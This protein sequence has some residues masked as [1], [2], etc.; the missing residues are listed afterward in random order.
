[1]YPL[2]LLA[3][4]PALYLTISAAHAQQAAPQD[5]PL[6]RKLT[7]CLTWLDSL[8]IIPD[9]PEPRFI[10]TW[11]QHW[12]DV[13]K[14]YPTVLLELRRD[15]KTVFALSLGLWGE[16]WPLVSEG[17]FGGPPTRVKTLEY[18][19]AFLLFR[20]ELNARLREHEE[21]LYETE[22]IRFLTFLLISRNAKETRSY[23]ELVEIMKANEAAFKGLDQTRLESALAKQTLRGLH[24]AVGNGSKEAGQAY[25]ELLAE[26]DLFLK[27]FGH[28]KFAPKA[29]KFIPLL[30]KAI[31]GEE[32]H[33]PASSEEIKKMAARKDVAG[34]IHQLQ[35]AW[36]TTN[37]NGQHA[38][39]YATES[40]QAKA[41]IAL[42]DAAVPQLLDSLSD[43]RLT[44]L[45]TSTMNDGHFR[46][47]SIGECSAQL[48]EKIML[49][50]DFT[51]EFKRTGMF[52][53]QPHLKRIE[54]QAR[55][56]WGEYQRADPIKFWTEKLDKA[57]DWKF[58]EI[59]MRIARQFPG[60]SV[61][62]LQPRL[63]SHPGQQ[64][65]TFWPN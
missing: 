42:G 14:D 51:R 60:K 10:R 39:P 24:G 19:R 55:R 41:L 18:R 53:P 40:D 27:R 5:E 61:A 22:L 3:I 59:A 6:E 63:K 1:M 23:N 17:V 34:L 38:S 13:E 21:R 65:G 47:L 44:R 32:R 45:G 49:G 12:V 7:E 16:A 37:Y 15:D 31:A 46:V 64:L 25:R 2:K 62:I 28:T 43:E 8:D 33:P 11:N 30:R 54:E 50:A 9:R 20:K 36:G 26:V 57:E 48:L 52:E 56:W 29:K 58:V 35:Y 4:L